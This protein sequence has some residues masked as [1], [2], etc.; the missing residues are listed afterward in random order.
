MNDADENG[1][2]QPEEALEP[3]NLPYIL[4][5]GGGAVAGVLVAIPF[6]EPFPAGILLGLLVGGVI[7]GIAPHPGMFAGLGGIA[8]VFGWALI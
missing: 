8:G 3:S 5:I 4:G 7:G 1:Q 2:L 6:Y